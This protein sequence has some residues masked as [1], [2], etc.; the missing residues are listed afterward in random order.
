MEGL[1][2]QGGWVL[3]WAV[4][5]AGHHRERS[6]QGILGESAREDGPDGQPAVAQEGVDPTGRAPGGP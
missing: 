3:R 4:W 2:G 5:E 6:G 1:H